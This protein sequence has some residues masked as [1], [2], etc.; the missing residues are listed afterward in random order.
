MIDQIN[1]EKRYRINT[2]RKPK[3]HICNQ[4]RDMSQQTHLLIGGTTGSGKSVVINGI[5]HSI[6]VEK[7]FFEACLI[8]ID[9]KRVELSQWKTTANCIYYASDLAQILEA[10]Q[11]A[12]DM[13]ERRYRLMQEKEEKVWH[14]SEIYVIIDE[15][16]DIM[17]TMRKKAMP[18]IQRICQI[19]RAAKVHVIAATQ[20]PISDVIPTAIKVNFDALLGLHTR[21]AQDSRNII[22][23]SGCEDLPRYG[24]GYYIKPE[25]KYLIDLP[26]IPDEELGLII[27]YWSDPKVYKLS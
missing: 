20:C 7:S 16:A 4:Y 2:V 6:L 9:P 11:L 15:L 10:L 21:S 8:L 22:G 5:I 27:Q 17:T 18:K 24:K 12:I 13:I 3:G 19:G 14:G 23:M 26:Q 1:N 25:G